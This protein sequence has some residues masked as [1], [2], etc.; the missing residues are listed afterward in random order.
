[1]ATK[2]KYRPRVGDERWFVEWCV[3]LGKADENDP[4]SEWDR[5]SDVYRSRAV[6]TKEEAEKLAREV[7][8]M[9]QYGAVAYWPAEFVAYDEDHAAD[10]PHVGFWEDTGDAEHYEGDG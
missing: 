8:P 3:K 4:D 6:A 2:E 9:D 5:D 7:Y 1:M 10:Y